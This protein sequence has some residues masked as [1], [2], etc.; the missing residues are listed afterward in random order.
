[1][2]IETRLVDAK[3]IIKVLIADDLVLVLFIL[4]LWCDIVLVKIQ[5]IETE[6]DG[7]TRKNNDWMEN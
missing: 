5:T 4:N 3:L 7:T 6:R 1:M 2:T